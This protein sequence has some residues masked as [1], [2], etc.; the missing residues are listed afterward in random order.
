ML[1]S[2]GW[3]L[4]TDVSGQT[5]GHTFKDQ[6]VLYCLILEGGS[7]YKSTLCNIPEEQK[8]HK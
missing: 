2:N 6:A 5:I 4:V 8:R 3:L 1:C 7:N